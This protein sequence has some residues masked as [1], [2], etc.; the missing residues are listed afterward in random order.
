LALRTDKSKEG[1]TSQD[2]LKLPVHGHYYTC[3]RGGAGVCKREECGYRTGTW[4]FGENQGGQAVS[5]QEKL[6]LIL[7]GNYVE[8]GR[9][10]DV[11]EETK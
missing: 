6:L 2:T 10:N 3:L 11:T 8:Q 5:K 4:H 7:H 1:I 9:R